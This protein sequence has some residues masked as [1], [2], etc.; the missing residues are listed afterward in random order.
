MQMSLMKFA[1]LGVCLAAWSVSIEALAQSSPCNQSMIVGKWLIQP[2]IVQGPRDYT[3]GTPVCFATIGANG[4]V[5][6]KNCSA[7]ARFGLYDANVTG[8]LAIDSACHAS[9]AIGYTYSYLTDKNILN[10]KYNVQGSLTP[11]LFRSLDGSRLSGYAMG[12]VTITG[13]SGLPCR[14]APSTGFVSLPFEL[15]WIP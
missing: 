5:V 13:Q 10:C 8:N 12:K 14:G 11:H 4:V 7:T 15:I 1:R 6:A 3:S 2:Q 9:G